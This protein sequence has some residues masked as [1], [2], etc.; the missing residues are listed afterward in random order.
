MITKNNP[1]ET[2]GEV[3]NDM[4]F[5]ESGLSLGMK[6]LNS[7][8]QMNP[9]NLNLLKNWTNSPLGTYFFPGAEGNLTNSNK[10]AKP[11]IN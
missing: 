3:K 1:F 7:K 9:Y 6:S 5:K 4:L 11:G 2:S 8:G 10:F